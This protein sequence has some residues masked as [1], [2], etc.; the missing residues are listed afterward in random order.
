MRQGN[1]PV[2]RTKVQ[3]GLVLVQLQSVQLRHDDQ[4]TA[5]N[6]VRA[7]FGVH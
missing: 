2:R 6:V 7:L 4:D 5:V 1:Q 3:D